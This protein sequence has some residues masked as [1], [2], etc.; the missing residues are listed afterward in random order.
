MTDDFDFLNDYWGGDE[1]EDN[2]DQGDWISEPSSAEKAFLDEIFAVY[3]ISSYEEVVINFDVTLDPRQ[4]RG[5][6]FATFA[7]A[8]IWLHDIGVLGFSNIVYY[9]EEELYGAKIPDCTPGNPNC[10]E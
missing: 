7:E 9:E 3:G 6:R 5:D 8:V 1:E 4:L 2:P 10:P